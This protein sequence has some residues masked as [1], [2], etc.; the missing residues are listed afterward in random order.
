VG[1][2]RAHTHILRGWTVRGKHNNTTLRS[3]EGR[4]EVTDPCFRKV[5]EPRVMMI[6]PAVPATQEAEAGGL[7]VGGSA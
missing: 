6:L 7:Q 5:I 3:R 2:S 1:L 4:A